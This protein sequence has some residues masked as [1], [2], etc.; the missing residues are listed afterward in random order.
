MLW[1]NIR[2]CISN[3]LRPSNAMVRSL[4]KNE[5]YLYLRMLKLTSSIFLRWTQF[6]KYNKETFVIF[7]D[8]KID[9]FVDRCLKITKNDRCPFISLHSKVEKLRSIYKS[10]L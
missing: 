2:V 4:L 8:T 7:Q 5:K 10:S 1:Y 9:T 6:V 3:K